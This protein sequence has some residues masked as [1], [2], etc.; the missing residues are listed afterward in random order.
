MIW[1]KSKRPGT[2]LASLA[3]VHSFGSKIRLGLLRVK[4]CDG[5]V[6]VMV[7]RAMFDEMLEKIGRL[8]LNPG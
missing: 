7:T 1:S 8:R 5:L 3:S 6:E 2:Y 4:T